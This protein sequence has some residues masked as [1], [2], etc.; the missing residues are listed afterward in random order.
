MISEVWVTRLK[1][2][3][4]ISR[5]SGQVF[6]S[7]NSPTYRH[8]RAS[9]PSA[10]WNPLSEHSLT[11]DRACCHLPCEHESRTR[12]VYIDYTNRDDYCKAV[13]GVDFA[14]VD[15]RDILNRRCWWHWYVVGLSNVDGV[16][17]LDFWHRW[18]HFKPLS[19]PICWYLGQCIK[20][21]DFGT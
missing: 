4:W 1:A 6:T 7:F 19:S 8:L 16:Y 18:R 5:N 14:G 3:P 13:Y 9:R 21:S 11:L 15:R 2:L 12:V 17:T 10:H 20:P